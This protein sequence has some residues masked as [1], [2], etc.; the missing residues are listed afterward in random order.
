MP[1][2]QLTEIG[3]AIALAAVLDIAS[4]SFP[5]PRLM[6]GGSAAPDWAVATMSGSRP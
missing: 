3:L 4:K 2:R 1:L 5:V 6:Q